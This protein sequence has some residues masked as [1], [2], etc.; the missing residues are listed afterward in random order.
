ML[1]RFNGTLS[2]TDSRPCGR[3]HPRRLRGW[4]P[5]LEFL[6]TRDLPSGVFHPTYIIDHPIGASAA[7]PLSTSGPTGTTPTQIRHAYGFDQITF[8]NGSVAG[9]GNGET[10]AIVDAYDDPQIANDLHQ[11]D[12][13][14]GLPDPTFTK[15][16]QTGGSTPPAASTSWSSEIALDVEWS[17]VIAP[18]AH[19]LLVEAND[20]SFTNLFTAVSYAASVPGVVAVSTSWGGGEFSG[21][22]SYDSTFTTPSGHTGITFVASSG[23]SG[24]PPIYPAVSPNVLAVGG[25]TLNMDSSGNIVSESGWSGSGGGISSQEAQP[26]YQHG[27]VTQTSTMRANPDVAYDADPNTGFP[28]YDTENNP[29]SA[30]WSQFGGTSDAAPQWAGLIAVADQGRALAG[31]GSLNGASQTLP[32]L[33]GLPASDFHDITSGTSTG[34][35]NYS[36]GP[37]YDL[38]TGRGTPVANLIVSALVGNSASAVTHYSVT[39]PSTATA[40]SAFSVTVSA[41][42]SSNQVVSGYTGTIHFTSSDGQAV[43]PANYTFTSGDAGTHTFTVTLKTAGSQSI[44]ATDT[45]TSSITGSGTV[46]VSPG[47]ASQ[48]VFGQQPSN[49]LTNA[50][51]SPAPTVKIFDAYGNLESGDNTDS[52]TMAIGTNPGGGT[53]S[54]TLTV[55]ASAGVA[56]F[57]N[58]SIN[59]AGNGYTLSASSGTLTGATSSAFNVTAPVATHFAVTVPSTATAGTAFSI[60]VQALD[61]NNH[62]ATGYTGTVHFT[63]SDGQAVLPANYTFSSGD[64]GSHTFTNGV[65]LKTAGS[66]SVT[67]TDTV[68]SSITGSGSITVSAAAASKLVFGQQPTN[69]VA[70]STI[71]PAVTVKVQDAYGN[72]ETGDNSDVVTLAIGT[73]PG[74]GTLSG[75]TSVTVSGGVATFSNLSINNAGNGYT[76]AAS[77]GSLAG[78]TSNAFNITAASSG[79]APVVTYQASQVIGGN[80]AVGGAGFTNVSGLSVTLTTGADNVRISGTLG[81]YNKNTAAYNFLYVRILVDGAVQGGPYAFSLSAATSTAYVETFS[82]ENDIALAAGTH[83]VVVQ[84]TSSSTSNVVWDPGTAQTLR[85]MDYHTFNSGSDVSMKQVNANEGLPPTFGGSGTA[86]VNGAFTTVPGLSTSFSTSTTDTL[87]LAATLSVDNDT[88]NFENL[89]VRFVVD[90][91]ATPVQT[92][93]ITPDAGPDTFR[94]FQFENDLLNV[95]AGTHTISV[96]AMTTTGANGL[97]FDGGSRTVPGNGGT[98]GNYQT[99]RIID[100]TTIP[101]STPSGSSGWVS[102]ADVNASVSGA[103]AATYT[104]VPGLTSTLTLNASG[105]VR[106]EATLNVYNS[107]T[108]AYGLPAARFLIDGVTATTGNSWNVNFVDSTNDSVEEE[109]V[110][111][112]FVTLAAGAHTVTVQAQSTSGS[113]FFENT[114]GSNQTLRVAAFQAVSISNGGTIGQSIVGAKLGELSSPATGNSEAAAHGPAFASG[115]SAGALLAPHH[116][117]DAFAADLVFKSPSTLRLNGDASALGFMDPALLSGVSELNWMS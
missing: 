83:T 20:S 38:V 35:P 56:T 73:N 41:L 30:P 96:Q 45:S 59:N 100:Y 15:V 90:G 47:A 108:T 92:F 6:E 58:L 57:G 71:T 99:L 68:S 111:E 33:Y 39:A 54:G 18:A 112:D 34:S 55:T 26:S 102:T 24:A 4:Q 43:L 77:S 89:E 19:I 8:N 94:T 113:M 23:D 1:A 91:T 65:T 80:T 79:T 95:G 86:V 32:M 49:V 7:H 29:V 110:F 21:E 52:V 64:A 25:T 60:T 17:H 63:S 31:E 11:F 109:L 12:L 22:T 66:Q 87:R 37:G 48:L 13:Q 61:A 62:V 88:L 42:N 10:I 2:H 98:A 82:F 74:S 116:P 105:T 115:S 107:S 14:F 97:W 85:V 3:R 78:A 106:L 51:I 40:G 9:N 114:A 46:S 53:L 75:T 67:A 5:F 70:G 50:A 117:I 72:A 16:N 28:V 76:L 104:N 27:I 103:L 44:T 36:A 93:W 69:T 101:K 81:A 84:A